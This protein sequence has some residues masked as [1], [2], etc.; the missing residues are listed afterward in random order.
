MTSYLTGLFA[1]KDKA[2]EE[3]IN[4]RENY[5][6]SLETANKGLDEKAAYQLQKDII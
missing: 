6:K 5:K 1:K 3:K 2:E 4:V